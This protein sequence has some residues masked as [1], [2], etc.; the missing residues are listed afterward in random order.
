M[1]SI[2]NFLKDGKDH[3]VTT[4]YKYLLECIFNKS[5]LT[6]LLF[7]TESYTLMDF[8]S[9]KCI[10]KSEHFVKDLIGKFEKNYQIKMCQL[11]LKIY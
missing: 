9:L 6:I 8:K 2:Y 3:F 4:T 10:H 5:Y 1:H 11:K 7:R